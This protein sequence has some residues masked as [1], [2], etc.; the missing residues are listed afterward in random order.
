MNVVEAAG[1]LGVSPRRV[2]ALIASGRLTAHKSG[3]EWV[4][5]RL[6]AGP[7]RRRRP[8]S[9][10]SRELLARSLHDRTLHGLTGQDRARTAARLREL[11]TSDDPGQLLIEW[12]GGVAPDAFGFAENLVQHAVAGNRY[13]VA[14]TL[15]RRPRE[16]LRRREDLADVVSGERAILG[17][18]RQQLADSAGVLVELVRSIEAGEPVNSPAAIRRIL[19]AVNVEPTALPDA[20]AA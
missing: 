9:P 4:I 12:W 3:S 5:P 14:E 18:S 13:Y 20:E 19:R 16:Y 11:R 8:L 7:R 17:M 10:R 2:R 15:R 1:E 6:D